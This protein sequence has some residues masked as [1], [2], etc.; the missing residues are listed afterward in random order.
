MYPLLS[1]LRIIEGASFI[2]APLCG[3]TFA[4]LGAEV[5][6]F[7][8]VG[9][10]LDYG[11]WP[12]AANGASLY[13]EGL[14]KGKKSVALD[15]G[16]PEGRELAAAIVTAPGENAGLFVTNY[17]SG[18]FLAHQRLAQRRADLIT[19][20][21]TGSSDG[22]SALDYTINSA[23][24]YPWMTGPVGHDR[25]VNNVLPAW[26][27]SCGLTAA[28]TLLS[29]ERARRAGTALVAGGEIRIALSDIAFSTLGNLGQIAEVQ[30]NDEERPRI[31]ND[32]FGAFGR[33]FRTRDGRFVMIC[34]ITR[35]QWQSL[36]DALALNEPVTALQGSLGV[37]FAADEGKRFEHRATL[38][39]MVAQQVARHDYADCGSLFDRHQVCW[40][41][42]RTVRQGLA[43]DKR[44]SE[45]NPMFATVTHPSGTPYL[46]PGFPAAI[47]AIERGSPAMAPRL[48]QHTEQVLSEVLGLASAEIGRLVDARL[49]AQA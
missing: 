4:Q 48:G 44:L 22:T 7:D 42:Y 45:Q 43:E 37:D 28:V 13:W 29:A 33:D 5:I 3:L 47:D 31:G 2:A 17:P 27:I 32:L 11:R 10:G 9:G 34:A 14:N 41:P 23:T 1:G 15:L 49:V 25:P 18:G 40:G 26:D 16:R 46:T 30:V 21:V 19:L 36:L 20:R 38:Y 39:E 8:Q 35:K 6:R 12:I 24:G